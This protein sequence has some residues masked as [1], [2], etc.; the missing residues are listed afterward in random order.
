MIDVAL[1]TGYITLCSFVAESLSKSPISLHVSLL[2]VSLQGSPPVAINLDFPV[3]PFIHTF[4]HQS[5]SHLC[6]SKLSPL[7]R[8]VMSPKWYTSTGSTVAPCF[9]LGP[10]KS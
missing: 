6:T 9:A 3:N 4:F 8:L 7:L 1:I 2:H 10:S 5:M